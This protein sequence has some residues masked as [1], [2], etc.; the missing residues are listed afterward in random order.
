MVVLA[1]AFFAAMHSGIHGH[2]IR[3]H[4]IVAD[5]GIGAIQ[6]GLQRNNARQRVVQTVDQTLQTLDVQTGK[7]DG[8]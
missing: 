2:D 6:F 8:R 4:F 3:R 7:G 5:H 1:T